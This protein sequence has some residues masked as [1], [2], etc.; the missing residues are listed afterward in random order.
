MARVEISLLPFVYLK[1]TPLK[2]R[3]PYRRRLLT[4]VKLHRKASYYLPLYTVYY[5]D[6]Q[7][8][9]YVMTFRIDACLKYIWRNVLKYTEGLSQNNYLYSAYY[10]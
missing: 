2:A 7:C 10:T 3:Q 9:T 6:I 5:V 1:D 4:K 8:T